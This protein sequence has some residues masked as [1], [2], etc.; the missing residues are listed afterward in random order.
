MQSILSK[1]ETNMLDII[2]KLDSVVWKPLLWLLLLVSINLLFKCYGTSLRRVPGPL[3]ARFS[4]LWKLS[5]AWNQ[6]MPRR[7]MEAHHKYGPV[8]RIGHNTVSVSDPSALTSV[9]S[10]QAWDKSAFYPI[11]EAL[12]KGKPVPNMF[13]TRST[14]YHSRLKRSSA[15]AY[16]MTSLRDL[17]PYINSCIELL[18]KRISEVTESGRKPLNT[19]VWLQYFAYDVLG[20]VN[21]SQKLGFLETGTDVASSV[22]AID[23]LLQYLSI[24]GQMPWLHNFLLGNPLMHKLIPQLEKSNEIQNRQEDP[25]DARRDILARFLEV[26]N[27]DPSKFTF[28]EMLGLTTTN[29]IAGSGTTSVALRAVLYYL[30]RNPMAY[31]KLKDEILDSEAASEI[32]KP[33]TYAEA[34]KLEYL[35]AVINETLR[36]HASTGFILE[37]MVPK[38]GATISDVYLPEGTVVGLNTW[39]LHHDKTIFGE[40]A[41]VYRPERWIESS[42]DQLK[43]M[44]RCMIAFGTG[45]R[46][47]IGKNIA[48]MEMCKVIPELV[49]AYDWKL[50]HPEREWKVLGHWFTKQTDMDMIFSKRVPNQA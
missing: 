34:S 6:D 9:Y 11:V 46:A 21:F 4:N 39:V 44:K 2:S 37:R 1:V 19:S 16:S 50:A 3:L 18:L 38:G 43:E 40:D 30:C 5:A 7:N 13:T 26:H 14:N 27:K 29:L 33:I 12:Y 23:G 42:P 17:E 35:S 20:E 36:V 8:V 22:A 48:M 15:N 32:S 28:T 25:D 24:V 45:P 49:R 10:F 41:D 31:K 47:C